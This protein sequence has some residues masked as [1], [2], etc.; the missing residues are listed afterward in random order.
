MKP[1][2]N[3]D[4]IPEYMEDLRKGIVKPLPM[5]AFEYHYCVEYLKMIR[6]KLWECR[7]DFESFT[8]I[9]GDMD[10]YRLVIAPVEDCLE[11]VAKEAGFEVISETD[12]GI[13]YDYVL[14][15]KFWEKG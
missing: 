14:K 10:N 13:S 6:R 12:T 4:I 2:F 8:L 5:G 1:S 15:S 3:T 11:M 9:F 7:K